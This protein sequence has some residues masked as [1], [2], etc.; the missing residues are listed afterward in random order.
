MSYP[1]KV[2]CVTLGNI[3]PRVDI[4]VKDYTRDERIKGCDTV[5]SVTI[6]EQCNKVKLIYKHGTSKKI[7][8]Q[9][10]K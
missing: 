1:N 7:Q 4:Q 9:W 3:V 8:K 6:Y 2:D 10:T 5:N